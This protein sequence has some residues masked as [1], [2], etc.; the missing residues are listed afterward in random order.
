M[1]AQTNTK[2]RQ[3]LLTARADRAEYTRSG[4][5]LG[6][7]LGATSRLGNLVWIASV[8]LWQLFGSC[9]TTKLARNRLKGPQANAEG[10]FL[11]PLSVR[12]FPNARPERPAKLSR[13]RKKETPPVD[14][15]PS[16]RRTAGARL[17]RKRI[18]SNTLHN[19]LLRHDEKSCRY[20]RTAPGRCHAHLCVITVGA[21]L[22]C[23][24]IPLL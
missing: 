7:T 11:C 21:A 12:P 14:P 19:A 6:A 24:D 23:R 3:A 10:L 20:K 18:S 2:S 8:A 4:V 5:W 17:G 9:T 15:S 22:K 13:W 16:F 1:R